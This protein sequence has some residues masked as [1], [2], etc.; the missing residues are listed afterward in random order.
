MLQSARLEKSDKIRVE[1]LT[2]GDRYHARQNCETPCAE[3]NALSGD[4]K[5]RAFDSPDQPLALPLVPAV[6]VDTQEEKRLPLRTLSRTPRFRRTSHTAS[7]APV[8]ERPVGGQ[9]RHF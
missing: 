8:H 5:V 3:A 2:S 4:R 1:V 6:H 7:H 9:S